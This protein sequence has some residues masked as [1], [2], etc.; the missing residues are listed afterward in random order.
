M[1]LNIYTPN[2]SNRQLKFISYNYF[3]KK[4]EKET[5]KT[6]IGKLIFKK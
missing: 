6:H 3:P 4:K 2:L 5:F 1:I